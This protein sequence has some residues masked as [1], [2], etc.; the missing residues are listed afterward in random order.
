MDENIKEETELDS[1]QEEYIRGYNDGYFLSKFEPQYFKEYKRE[2]ERYQ[3]SS[4]YNRGIE[5]GINQFEKEK[6]LVRIHTYKT[7]TQKDSEKER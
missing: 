6:M 2:V 1:F 7:R 4:D 5:E 3:F